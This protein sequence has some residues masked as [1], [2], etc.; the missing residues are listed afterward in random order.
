[1]RICY[2]NALFRQIRHQILGFVGI[3]PARITH[4]RMASHPSPNDVDGWM[5]R[6]KALG[7]A[8]A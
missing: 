5:R 4:F 6:V 8:A 1:M 2:G 3:A 7:Q